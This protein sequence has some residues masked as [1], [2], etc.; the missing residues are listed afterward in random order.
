MEVRLL[1]P[2]EIVVGAHVVRPSAAKVRA[3]LSLLALDANV[4]VPADALV[5]RL[6]TGQ[7]PRSA[8]SVLRTYV[9]QLRRH[10]EDGDARLTRTG[11][12]YALQLRRDE[13]DVSRF[14][15]AVATATKPGLEA[16]AV[17]ALLE[18]ALAMWRGAPYAELHD[19]P[20]AQ[21]E[22][23][24]LQAR[25][26]A[27]VAALADA[28][29][30]LGLHEAAAAR[31]EASVREEPLLE[32]LVGGLMVAL[33]R[34][35]RQADAL[36]AFQR[37][38]RALVEEL[39]LEPSAEL[40]RLESSVLTQDPSLDAPVR[41]RGNVPAPV[42]SFV[43]RDD[44]TAR[45]VD[46][47][48]TSRLVT[49]T[50]PGGSGKTRL[51][52]EV[53]RRIEDRPDGVWFV[54][55]AARGGADVVIAILES[56]DIEPP[57]GQDAI[58]FA[59]ATL[60]DRRLLV[61]LDNCEHIASACAEAAVALLHAAPA[62]TVLA[63]SRSALAVP[64]EVVWPVTPLPTPAPGA[65]SEEVEAAPAVRLLVDRV[66][67]ARGGRP[68]AAEWEAVAE[69]SRRLDGL[70]LA[71]ELIAPRASVLSISDLTRSISAHL[72]DASGP[73]GDDA[74]RR[75][76]ASCVQWSVSLLLDGDRALLERVTL[77]PGWFSP[78]PAAAVSGCSEE[79]ATIGLVRLASHSLLE[80]ARDGS[81]RLRMLETV[82]AVVRRSLADVE[83]G[84]ALDALAR[85]TADW[86]EAIEPSLR[87]PGSARV[88][89]DLDAEREVLHATLDHA[90]SSADP[91]DGLRIAAAISAFWTQ[92]G[93]LVD[94]ARRL[95]R[96][97]AM[98]AEAPPV[99]RVR[100]LVSAGTHL[101]AMGDLDGF[102]EQVEAALDLVRTVA[103]D[104]AMVRVLL[105]A[106]HAVNLRGEHA[107]AAALYGEALS[108]ADTAGDASSRASAL[109]G[110]GDVA[111]SADRLDEAASL[112]LRSLS[113][114][115]AA[116]DAHGEGQALL[117]LA[118][119]D[120]RSA[121]LAGSRRR[122]DEAESVFTSIADRSCLAATVEG[123]ARI[124][125]DEG[126]L[127]EA[128]QLYFTALGIRRD[129]EQDRH[130][131]DDLR[132]MASLRARAGRPL[133]AAAALGAAGDD[134]GALAV[135]LRAELGERVYL[136][137]WSE[138]S[139]ERAPAR[140]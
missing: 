70:P 98:S 131:S 2:V 127:D 71:I 72:A 7:P 112:H 78:R 14:D 19:D 137:A 97:V 49:L 33:Y 96:A 95:D 11:D 12:G 6:W 31:L 42:T 87:G 99:L 130:A 81:S 51:A 24:R 58:A 64:G 117:N 90:L 134:D 109:A 122:L 135:E 105:W 79:Q 10:F 62:M 91:T 85:T 55:L 43:G 30:D 129:L 53:A 67:A 120:R 34:S 88:L 126:R 133:D 18:Q 73:P 25:R 47:L 65:R 45:L 29:L 9:T 20:R 102:R 68:P 116:G 139:L 86:A 40:R 54:E 82:R 124:A 59:R 128:E 8:A 38:R 17:V 36:A 5:D 15:E 39:G 119:I 48:A 101:M 22:S 136:T 56:M 74:R 93:H 106:G 100:L 57:S 66:A 83:A 77:L 138:G 16:H 23:A 28:E 108:L 26:W 94:G 61:V 104:E 111:A 52:V 84:R 80:S 3:L 44:D 121:Q 114:F 41:Q 4:P 46:L 27:A 50:G 21:A 113:E 125:A 107:A 63:T 118:E 115:R 69:L 123:R 76:L 1:G 103:D 35:G 75:D 132:A 32:Q 89:G 13:L 92:R 110:L 60:H 140:R 37:L